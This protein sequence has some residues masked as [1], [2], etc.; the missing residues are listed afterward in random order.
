VVEVEHGSPQHDAS[1]PK[2]LS[3][4]DLTFRSG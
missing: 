4:H 2:A 1:F 3:P